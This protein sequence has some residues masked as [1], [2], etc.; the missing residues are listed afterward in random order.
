MTPPSRPMNDPLTSAYPVLDAA[1]LSELV[2][3]EV[4]AGGLRHKPGRSTSASLLS[5]GAGRPLGWV[6]IL[7]GHQP[8]KVANAR[9]RA[10]A[11]GRT[12]RVR[13]LPDVAGVLV[14]GPIDTDPRLHRGLAT[15]SPVLPDVGAAIAD[16]AVEVLRYNALRRLVLRG[17]DL[18]TSGHLH[19]G[20]PWEVAGR[21][22]T[23]LVDGVPSTE[24]VRV[25]A[26]RRGP[27]LRAAAELAA[28][29]LPVGAAV[30]DPVT[31]TSRHVTVWP[32]VHGLDLA[33][34]PDGDA[35]AAAARALAG[36]HIV[37][38]SVGGQRIQRMLTPGDPPRHRVA[39]IVT[40]ALAIAP[41]LSGR[42]LPLIERLPEPAWD[43]GHIV[44]GDFSADQ[45]IR[46]DATPQHRGTEAAGDDI[47]IIDLDRVRL[48]DPHEDL[49]C[50]AAAE[51]RRTGGWGLLPDL[52]AAYPRP[53]R[54]G[55]L[56]AW[57]L[58]ALVMRLL[59][60]FRSAA[61]DWRGEISERLD[62]IDRVLTEGVL[63]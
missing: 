30:L 7:L 58:H 9:R 21:P 41:E 53:V 39:R 45:V 51:L 27:G 6:Q 63:S 22:G 35:A 16:G 14:H 49:G 25:S 20:H 33:H 5:R 43:T 52:V 4:C 46:R 11:R 18:D 12:V 24:V 48:G 40:D 26:V 54:R 19:P 15:I 32:W 62:E 60:P 55:S 1:R 47:T 61:P 10:S 44:H 13:D 37:A 17:G 57:T 50:F 2:E 28:R 23:G 34:T 8:E 3:A 36:I 42:M 56:H 59:E 38:D 29:G 31:P